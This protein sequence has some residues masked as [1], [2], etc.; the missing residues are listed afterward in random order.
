MNRPQ[1]LAKLKGVLT[2]K[3]NRLTNVTNPESRLTDPHAFRELSMAFRH[4]GQ[5]KYGTCIE[6]GNNISIARLSIKP[7]AV[8]CI[9]CQK[10]FENMIT[11]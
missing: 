2:D 4:I 1:T 7:E 3:L 9:K 6:C 8:H 11:N 5:G 10:Q